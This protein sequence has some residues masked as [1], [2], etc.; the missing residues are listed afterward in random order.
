MCNVG[1]CTMEEH[2]KF[3]IFNNFPELRYGLSEKKDGSMN[4]PITIDHADHRALVAKNRKDFLSSAGI[5]HEKIVEP[6]LVH[7]SRAVVIDEKNYKE[8]HR[9][10]GFITDREEIALTI[11][12]ADCFPLYVSDRVK[13]VVGLSHA[14]WRGITQGIVEHTIEAF[15]SAF[16]SDPK[17]IFLGIGPGIQKCHF[18]IRDDSIDKFKHYSSFVKE[19]GNGAYTVN[20]QGIIIEKAIQKGIRTIEAKSEC[21]YCE[22]E[23]YF[24]YRRDKPNIPEVMLAY[25]GMIY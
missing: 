5:G 18:E 22:S 6:Y 3:S 15:V 8:P 21:T 1:L 23:T 11:T 13:R 2:M 9:A 24:S 16:G 19:K 12:V 17:D 10:D 20:L 4:S 7:G 25:I 14:G